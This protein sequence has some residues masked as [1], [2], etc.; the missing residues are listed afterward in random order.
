MAL[1]VFRAKAPKT[2][3]E[4][5][6]AFALFVVVAAGLALR[7]RLAWQSIDTIVRKTTP[8]DA[9]YYLQIARN[10]AHGHNVTF[11]G[12]T[13]TN[14][15]HPLWMMLITPVFFVVDGNNMPVHIILT[16]G[17]VLG[18]ATVF[19]I[20][21]VVQRLTGSAFAAL[22]G[23]GFYALHPATVADSVN[24]VE[25]AVTVFMFVVVVWRFLDLLALV[26]EGTSWSRARSAAFGALAG[27][28]ILARTDMSF[29]VV[30]MILFL[31]IRRNP[32]DHWAQYGLILG[33][34][35]LVLLPFVVWSLVANGT[36]V[37][38]SGIA[39]AWLGRNVYLAN[40]GRAWTT[41]F[42]HS[43]QLT[44]L[45][46]YDNF[47]HLY[48]V[49]RSSPI[50]PVAAL[51][52]FVAVLLTVAPL[53]GHRT[54][55]FRSRAAVIFVPAAGLIVAIVFH[56]G[57]RWHVRSWYYAPGGATL[58]MFI[59]L[60]VDHVVR[61]SRELVGRFKREQAAFAVLALQAGIAVVLLAFYRPST[62]ERWLFYSGIQ[63]IQSNILETAY[64]LDANTPKDARI[65]APN[66][67]ILGYYSNRTVVNLDGVV[68][69]DALDA[70]Q[71]G[72]PGQ[73]VRDKR[74]EYLVDLP[75]ALALAG[76][77]RYTAIAT[78]GRMFSYFEGGQL[79]VRRLEN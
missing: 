47:M 36:V 78:I 2:L 17:A 49:P 39:S 16:M 5:L 6:A 53:R 65:G 63:G 30:A 79:E 52:A 59:G 69:T 42:G 77:H 3:P 25:S 7:L 8:D 73:Y 31:A 71:A 29:V 27:L 4:G 54:S 18:A 55:P 76:V 34:C 37:Q 70:I 21:V 22:I 9:Y 45:A 20:Y 19:L 50:W 43:L 68:N 51:I 32:R 72:R 38:V 40:H 46:L 56:A 57:I 24:G 48:V 64:W 74:I 28:M 13:V 14:G 11:D 67:G 15:F 61:E 12:E 44:K 26:D 10:I 60:G 23:A 35:A 58:A 62:Q 66:A 75:G 41:Q 1:A 33:T